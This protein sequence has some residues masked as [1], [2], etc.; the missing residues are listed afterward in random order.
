L[1]ESKCE[2]KDIDDG[3]C[4]TDQV[5]FKGLLARW[6]GAAAEI[7]PEVKEDVEK[8]I[9][10]AATAVQDGE[11]TDLGPI[12]SFNA[13]EVVDAS[14][15]MQGLGGVEGVIGLGKARRTKRSVAGRIS[16]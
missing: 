9:N 8:I 5:S 6:L 13:L 10:A 1:F 2:G 15:R 3:G 12:E 4:D 14:L 11:K 16:W 7:L